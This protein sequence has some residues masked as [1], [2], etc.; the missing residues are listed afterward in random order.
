MAT[1]TGLTAERMIEMEEATVIDGEVRV[2]NLILITRGGTEI[3]AGN[4]RGPVGPQGPAVPAG[5]ITATIRSTPDTGFLFID[6]STITNGQTVHPEL[7]NVIPDG[8]KSGGNIIFPDARGKML[9]GDDAALTLGALVGSNSLLIGAN[10]IPPHAH[11]IDHNHP[12]TSLSISDPGHTHGQTAHGHTVAQDSSG[13]YV[14]YVTVAAGG[15]YNALVLNGS[16][17][18]SL[19]MYA[20]G[21]YGGINNAY[22]GIYGSVDLPNFVGN[23]GNNTTTSAPLTIPSPPSLV[24]NWQI[25]T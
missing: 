4:V 24:V 15:N 17:G 23:S 20:I 22:T 3:D 9:V 10:N 8:W 6:G 14:Q 5:L 21:N 16:G 11:P 7:W 18:Y 12:S 19:P 13:A 2:D 1:V 25:K